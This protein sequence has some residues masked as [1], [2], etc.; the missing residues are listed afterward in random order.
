MSHQLEHR[1]FLLAVHHPSSLFRNGPDVHHPP[2]SSQETRLPF[3]NVNPSAQ[4]VCEI[5]IIMES[6]SYSVDITSMPTASRRF[7]VTFTDSDVRHQSVHFVKRHVN[8]RRTDLS[9]RKS[10]DEG[11]R[12][13]YLAQ[14]L[15]MTLLHLSE[16][17]EQSAQQSDESPLQ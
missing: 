4:F 17:K 6:Q 8:P 15:C 11:S 5:S 1:L 12:R 2:N 3:P 14:S 9:F 13:G 7:P 16:E 10:R